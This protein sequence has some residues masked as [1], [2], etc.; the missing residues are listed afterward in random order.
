MFSFGG[1]LRLTE[2]AS[3]ETAVTE[4]DGLHRTTPDIGVHTALRWML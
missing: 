3:L 4:D 2:G 1:A